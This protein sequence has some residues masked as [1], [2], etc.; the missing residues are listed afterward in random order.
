MMAFITNV[1]A[2][3]LPN[4]DLQPRV[5]GRD[6]LSW[7]FLALLALAAPTPQALE[8]RLLPVCH[9]TAVELNGQ[10]R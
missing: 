6:D 8:S 1:N 7:Q 3:N 5:F 9:V 4:Y 10:A 2:S